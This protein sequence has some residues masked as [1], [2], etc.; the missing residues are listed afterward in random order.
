MTIIQGPFQDGRRAAPPV[1]D[2]GEGEHPDLVED[3][4]A[5]TRQEDA[6]AAVAVHRPEAR[7]CV[8]VLLLVNDLPVNRRRSPFGGQCDTRRRLPTDPTSWTGSDFVQNW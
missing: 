5:Q 3:V 7:S 8:R 2:A 4:L 6:V 1:A